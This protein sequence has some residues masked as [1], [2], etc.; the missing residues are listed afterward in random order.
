MQHYYDLTD[1]QRS[2]SEHEFWTWETVRETLEERREERTEFLQEQESEVASKLERRDDVHTRIVEL[3]ESEIEKQ[4]QL[5]E[6]RSGSIEPDSEMRDR[7]LEL[8][9]SLADEHRSAFSDKLELWQKKWSVEE[10]LERLES[11][12]ADKLQ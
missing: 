4:E 3:L 7:V 6:K 8:K 2:E 11:G 12:A 10:E 9:L 5:M 1:G